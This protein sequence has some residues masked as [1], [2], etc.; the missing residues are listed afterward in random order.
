MQHPRRLGLD[1]NTTRLEQ[2]GRDE[3]S[4]LRKQELNR[5]IAQ[6]L[7]SLKRGEGI[8]GDEFFNKL[9]HLE[10]TFESNPQK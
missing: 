7:D 6:G 5:K 2:S 8:D 3:L 9:E 10:A 4:A 1:S